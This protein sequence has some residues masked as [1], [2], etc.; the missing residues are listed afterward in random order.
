M[1]SPVIKWG[2]DREFRGPF[3]NDSIATAPSILSCVVLA[4]TCLVLALSFV[5][6]GSNHIMVS[7]WSSK[8]IGYYSIGIAVVGILIAYMMPSRDVAKVRR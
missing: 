1:F 3:N 7:S 5:G 6:R 4:L 2:T 8:T